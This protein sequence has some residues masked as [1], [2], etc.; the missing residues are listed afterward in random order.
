MS[1]ENRYIFFRFLDNSF[2][3]A[4]NIDGIWQEV[5]LLVAISIRITGGM[6]LLSERIRH[7]KKELELSDADIA[8]HAGVTRQSVGHWVNDEV[9]PSAMAVINLD[10]NLS[11][12]GEWL[13]TGEGLP[14]RLTKDVVLKPRALAVARAICKMDDERIETIAKLV[15][16]MSVK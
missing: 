6:T 3:S 9:L 5:L 4:R 7:L 13:M 16:Y 2:I 11:V 12:N 8:R 15:D 10:K 14:F 1:T